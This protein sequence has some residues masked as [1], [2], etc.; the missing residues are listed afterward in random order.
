MAHALV[1]GGCGE[2]SGEG[3]LPAPVSRLWMGGRLTL[4]VPGT[5]VMVIWDHGRWGWNFL[6]SYLNP[7]LLLYRQRG[8]SVPPGQSSNSSSACV[9]PLSAQVLG[10]LGCGYHSV[11]VGNICA[12]SFE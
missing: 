9:M 8:V 4:G 6:Q 3:S 7:T 12:S 2:C 5:L 11:R 10:Q 1:P